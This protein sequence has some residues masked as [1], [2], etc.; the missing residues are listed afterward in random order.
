MGSIPEC[1]TK[2]GV[3]K[4]GDRAIETPDM[5]NIRNIVD[6]LGLRLFGNNIKRSNICTI[7]LPKKRKTG[8]LK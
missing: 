4:L 2:E 5:K 3:S 8:V 7:G 1:E 6:E